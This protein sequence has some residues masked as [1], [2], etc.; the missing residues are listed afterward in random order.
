MPT[1]PDTNAKIITEL[2]VPTKRPLCQTEKSCPEFSHTPFS[3]LPPAAQSPAF[4]CPEDSTP[5]P[6]PLQRGGKRSGELRGETAEPSAVIPLLCKDGDFF[7]RGKSREVEK[8]IAER[9]VILARRSLN[10]QEEI[11]R[12][13]GPM[14]NPRGVRTRKNPKRLALTARPKLPIS[15]FSVNVAKIELSR[16]PPTIPIVLRQTLW[17]GNREIHGVNKAEPIRL[18]TF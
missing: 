11:P 13:E 6:L 10:V 7:R 8:K 12:L 16:I 4:A 9:R 17:R 18:M 14:R 1:M 3:L 5:P 15:E 2:S